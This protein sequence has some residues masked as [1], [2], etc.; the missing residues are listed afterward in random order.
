MLW[1]R[2]G[3]ATMCALAIWDDIGPEELR[4]ERDGRDSGR[5]IA[6]SL[7]RW[8]GWIGPARCGWPGWTA[9]PRVTGFTAITLTELPGC[10]IGQHRAAGR[11]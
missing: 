11:S 10:A 9:R 7:T 8:K 1:L 4:R 6:R 2:Y 3:G 5:L